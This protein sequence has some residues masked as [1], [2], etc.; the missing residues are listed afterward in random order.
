MSNVPGVIPSAAA[1]VHLIPTKRNRLEYSTV[2]KTGYIDPATKNDYKFN[3]LPKNSQKNEKNTKNQK[4]NDKSQQ[5]NKNNVKKI[6]KPA[7]NP[8]EFTEVSIMHLLDNSIPKALKK[9][10]YGGSDT[11]IGCDYNMDIPQ[12]QKFILKSGLNL[13][14]CR[15]ENSSGSRY[16]G[17]SMGRMLD[18]ILYKSMSER[19][20]YCTV[21]HKV[22]LSDH[23]PIQAEWSIESIIKTKKISKISPK[24]IEKHANVLLNH[25]RFAVL[26]DKNADLDTLCNDTVATITDTFAQLE[27]PDQKIEFIPKILST[28]TLMSIKKRRKLFRLTK[29]NAD[30]ITLYNEL[31]A[32]TAKAI[33]N[34][35][36]LN[37]LKKLEAVT[38]DLIKNN[39]KKIWKWIK[40]K[41]R[42][43]RVQANEPVINKDRILILDPDQKM[44]VWAQHFGD[45]AQDISKNSQNPQKWISL[46]N[47]KDQ[48]FSKYFTEISWNEVIAALKN[49]HLNKTP[50]TDGLPSEI[51]KLVQNEPSQAQTQT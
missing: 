29:N 15:V 9:A 8:Q 49:I 21:S 47:S 45:L 37:Y 46:F 23:L 12:V 32:N 36:K 38:D 34:N 51:W 3:F 5:H 41:R 17:L 7:L 13:A 43:A 2:A 6:I 16:N 4:K 48:I 25:N 44:Q 35:V 1:G 40:N 30:I 14:R 28:K 42:T 39:S 33:K 50:G 18:H 27:N 22:D 11:K 19:P 10:C 26:A 20:N 31:K 24:I